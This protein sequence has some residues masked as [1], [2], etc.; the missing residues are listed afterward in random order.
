M[1]CKVL[2]TYSL[3][4]IFLKNVRIQ[5]PPRESWNGELI[6]Y[7]VNC[8]EEKQNIN[9]ISMANNS[10]KSVMVGGWATTKATLRSLKKYTRYSVSVRAINSFGSGPWST[11]II[12]TT[13]EG[14]KI[15]LIPQRFLYTINIDSI[16][17]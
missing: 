9:Y 5:I 15:Y 11:A 3:I 17:Y 13:A 2:P 6:G 12:G 7:T 8:S 16:L 14:G 1:T 10:H 4:N